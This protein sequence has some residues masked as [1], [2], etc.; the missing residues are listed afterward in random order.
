MVGGIVH[1]LDRERRYY[2]W[3]MFEL[4]IGLHPDD[5]SL[6][7]LRRAGVIEALLAEHGARPVWVDHD[8]SRR[9]IDLL[10]AGDLH[11]A[12]TGITPP[13]RAQSEGVDI[14]YVA[15][16]APRLVGAVVVVVVDAPIGELADL[17]G[18]RV[19]LA[20]GSGPTH[21]LAAALDGTRVAY[22]ELD[23]LLADAPTAR[24]A[25]LAGEVDAWVDD[26]PADGER[27]P[28]LRELARTA[29]AVA[30]RTVWFARRDL[31]VERPELVEALCGGLRRPP[32]EAQRVT[33]E[34]VREQQQAADLFAR[35]GVI[36]LPVN[37]TAAVLA[38]SSTARV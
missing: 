7:A 13:L 14:V 38:P 22:R 15:V 28:R 1:K 24:R 4:R 29:T 3:A 25:L 11:V 33:A 12:A 19:A 8:D 31:A 2:A 35:Q 26:G 32:L 10:A 16:S 21:A 6:A 23:V 37:V 34:V 36:Q 27:D 9:T 5:R 30:H 18:R 20:R 17:R